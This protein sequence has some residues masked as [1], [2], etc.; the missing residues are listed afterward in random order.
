MQKV[1]NVKIENVETDV[2]PVN[3]EMIEKTED[4]IQSVIITEEN[5]VNNESDWMRPISLK[6]FKRKLNDI[7]V[8][9]CSLTGCGYYFENDER[10]QMHE[11]CHVSTDVDQVR[12]FKCLECASESKL[13]RDC[14][15]HMWK[16]HK[17][18][19]DL[20]KCPFCSFKA[21]FAGK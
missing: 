17:I 5:D 8:I 19:I 11:K 10:R 6:G 18:D 1:E 14:T 9:K 20:L 2:V 12:Q 4:E 15:S 7:F 21:V 3:E 16:A 13:W